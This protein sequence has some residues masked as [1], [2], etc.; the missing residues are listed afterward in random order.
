MNR[1]STKCAMQKR[2]KRWGQRK[3]GDANV[4]DGKLQRG[5][6]GRAKR[7]EQRIK[8]KEEWNSQRANGKGAKGRVGKALV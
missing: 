3:V 7:K 6:G 5:N 2:T 4:D 8:K 1:G